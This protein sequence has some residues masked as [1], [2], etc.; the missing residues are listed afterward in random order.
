MITVS[1]YIPHS[2]SPPS[3]FSRDSRTQDLYSCPGV[4]SPTLK[5]GCDVLNVLLSSGLLTQGAFDAIPSTMLTYS[6]LLSKQLLILRDQHGPRDQ[7]LQPEFDSFDTPIVSEGA[8]SD[9]TYEVAD[10]TLGGIDGFNPLSPGPCCE[11][12]R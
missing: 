4:R 11:T 10:P 2:G 1:L 7:Q 3:S 8:R 6:A 12:M 5:F 9:Y